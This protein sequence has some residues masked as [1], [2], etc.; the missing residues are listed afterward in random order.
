MFSYIVILAGGSG[1]RL[2]PASTSSHPKQFMPLAD[3][4][5]FFRMAV[6][7]ALALSPARGILVVTGAS[8]AEAVER[9]CRKLPAGTPGRGTIRILPEPEGKNT[10]PAVAWA[11]AWARSEGAP[12]EGTMLLMTSDHLIEPLDVFAA[13]AA[14]A[15]ALAAS[16]RLVC[17]GI[18]PRYAATGYGYIEAAE[19][20]GPGRRAAGFREKPDRATAEGFLAAGNFFWN[21]GMYAFRA[22][23]MARELAACAPDIPRAFEALRGIPE[24][25]ETEGL[26]VVRGWEGLTEAYSRTPSISLDYAVSEKSDKVALVEASFTWDDVGSWD[27]LARLFPKNQAEVYSVESGNCF[28]YSDI[29]VA[30]CGVS[31]LTVVIRDGVALVARKGST[32][33]VK[34]AVE[35]VKAAGRKELL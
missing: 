18:P 29:P 13:D 23:M 35:A 5:S 15:E 19:P 1:T 6:D 25:A 34:N 28:V 26:R 32:Q 17:F 2:W 14:K 20:L 21:S 8:Q 16:G 4:S 33:L 7:R 11:L 30:L 22:D 24:M 31:D 9:E 12:P 3:G 27:E 10:A